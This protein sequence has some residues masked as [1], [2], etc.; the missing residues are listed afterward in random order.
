MQPCFEH[1]SL[2]K[3]AEKRVQAGAETLLRGLK[4]W[5]KVERNS[6]GEFGK[7]KSEKQFSNNLL[8]CKI[9]L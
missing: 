4:T 5:Q 7:E 3:D 8:I 1:G 9:F 6:V 2:K